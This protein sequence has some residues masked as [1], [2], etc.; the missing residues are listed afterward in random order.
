VL[1][2]VVLSQCTYEVYI[3]LQTCLV[4][5]SVNVRVKSTHIYRHT[6][7]VCVA[8]RVA[9][10]AMCVAMCVAVRGVGSVCV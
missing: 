5:I 10:R 3:N 1:Q 6:I 7:D 9:V 2:C 8:V 4:N